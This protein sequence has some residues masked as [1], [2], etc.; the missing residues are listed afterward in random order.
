MAQGAAVCATIEALPKQSRDYL[1]F[2]R[3]EVA[4]ALVNDA[5]FAIADQLTIADFILSDAELTGREGLGRDRTSTD[6]MAMGLRRKK[7]EEFLGREMT[8][9]DLAWKPVRHG[10]VVDV[11]S[12][13]NDASKKAAETMAAAKELADKN[14]AFA[15]A[16]YGSD[17]WVRLGKELGHGVEEESG[18]PNE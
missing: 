13:T 9:E 15:N 4:E 16:K 8:Q 17:E 18:E 3:D 12:Q 1:E 10:V 11:T 7:A 5:Y 6:T 2:S 14:E